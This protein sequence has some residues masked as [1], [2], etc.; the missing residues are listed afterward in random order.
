M[1]HIR[2]C[3][4][5][6]KTGTLSVV[7]GAYDDYKYQPGIAGYPST[8]STASSAPASKL[9]TIARCRRET[10]PR[11]SP[12]SPAASSSCHAH[13]LEGQDGIRLHEQ[14]HAALRDGAV[15]VDV[16]RDPRHGHQAP[17]AGEA[18]DPRVCGPSP[19]RWGSTRIQFDDGCEATSCANRP[20][21]QISCRAGVSSL[22][23]LIFGYVSVVPCLASQ[24]LSPTS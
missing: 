10:S 15:A 18:F 23:G 16:R 6:A 1:S 12:P 20:R 5:V 11:S 14:G 21:S 19:G 17:Q 7:R 22:G 8:S 24:A 9:Y 2:A 3:L 4:Q 13:Q